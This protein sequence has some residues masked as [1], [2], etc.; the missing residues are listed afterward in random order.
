[1]VEINKISMEEKGT[2]PHKTTE[3]KRIYEK[4]VI[5]GKQLN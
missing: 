5:N 2:K 1:M 3:T 4:T